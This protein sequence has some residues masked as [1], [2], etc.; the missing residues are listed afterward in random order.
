MV[1]KKEK[2]VKK[3]AKLEKFGQPIDKK[4]GEKVATEKFGQKL[5]E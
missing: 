2:E 4:F 5:G 1:K 3:K